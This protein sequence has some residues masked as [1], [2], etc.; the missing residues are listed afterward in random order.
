MKRLLSLAHAV[1]RLTDLF[2]VVAKW[3]VLASCLISA[4]NA[5]IRYFFNN[6]SNGWLEIQWYLFAACVM[7]GAAQ[8]LR[9]NEHVRVDLLYGRLSARAQVLVDLFGLVVLLLPVIGL[10][11]WMTWELFLSR[12]LSG[13]M[14]SNA[15]GLIRWPAVLMLPLGFGLVCLQALSEIVKRVAWL[16]NQYDMDTHYERPL[17]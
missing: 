4:G 9:V 13:E 17:Q 3:A 16:N 2:G 1:D 8:V 7:L 12:F 11:S 6:S 15:G 10:M 5:L 14:S